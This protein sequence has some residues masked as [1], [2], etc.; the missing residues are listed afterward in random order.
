M[1]S[2]ARL[3]P[4]PTTNKPKTKIITRPAH[5]SPVV[6]PRRQTRA[7]NKSLN[8]SIVSSPGRVIPLTSVVDRDHPVP[9]DIRKAGREAFNLYVA[10]R[11]AEILEHNRN[12]R[13]LVE[14]QTDRLMQL[15]PGNIVCPDCKEECHHHGILY[16]RLTTC[17][18][19]RL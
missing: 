6:R 18:N 13:I 12:V 5:K 17:P 10:Q 4:S 19:K 8:N 11:T 16:H 14:A 1:F 3:P 9:E 7:S 2:P 15:N